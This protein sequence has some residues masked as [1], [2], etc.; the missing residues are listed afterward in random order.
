MEYGDAEGSPVVALH[1]SLV[2]S[3]Y[4]ASQEEVAERRGVRLIAVDRPGYGNSTWHPNQT[5]ESATGDISRLA[6]HL[7][8]DGF[9]V[10]GQSSGGP[11]AAGCARFLD[12]R[13]VGCAIVSGV[14][15]PE[16]KISNR[17]QLREHR[18]ARRLAL[19]AP[20]LL[21]I[22]IQTALRHGQRAP[23]KV[24]ARMSRTL[25]AC[26][27]AV[28][29]RSEVRAGVREEIAR[30]KAS[31]AG[32]AATL[33]L[34]LQLRPWGF[35]I[36]DIAIPVHVWHGDLDR[37][38]VLEEGIYLAKQ[39]PGAAMHELSDAGHWLVHSHFADI[40][41]SISA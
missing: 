26:D 41:D 29:G 10:L 39:I 4:F 7:G 2:S 23:D 33:D 9:A 5:Y 25:P 11:Y 32:R 6:D 30:P 1:G 19:V 8:I 22:A 13:V 16:A 34:R 15:P 20:Q 35:R 24:L 17:Q 37:N 14:A 40:L 27:I 36:Q 12:D 21:G 38:V 18:I 28:V 31:T 3:Y